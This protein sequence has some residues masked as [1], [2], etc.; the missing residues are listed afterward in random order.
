MNDFFL[1]NNESLSHTFVDHK[2]EVRQVQIKSLN[3][4]AMHAEPLKEALENYSVETIKP[5]INSHIYQIMGLCSL[6]TSLDLNV[7]AGQADNHDA[8]AELVL[9]IIEVNEAY[10]KKEE[11]RAKPRNKK[12]YS[13]FDSFQYLMSANHLNEDIMNMSYGAFVAYLKVAQR[14]EN[15]KLRALATAVRMAQHAKKSDFEKYLKGLES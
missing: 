3:S 2:I 14:D 13:W 1:A 7:F 11:K 12:E 8:I 6:V 5:I 9:K 10:F 15:Q 4:F